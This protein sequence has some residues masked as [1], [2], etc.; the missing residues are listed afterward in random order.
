MTEAAVQQLDETKRIG[1]SVLFV[2]RHESRIAAG[3]PALGSS[4]GGARQIEQITRWSV[5]STD[6][7]LGIDFAKRRRG[8]RQLV[9]H[10][11]IVMTK[12]PA[13]R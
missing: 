1:R 5:G 6:L 2:H 13:V 3:P 12:L 11:Q 7:V 9:A 4:D 8:R 10:R